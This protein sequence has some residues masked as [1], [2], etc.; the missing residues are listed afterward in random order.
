MSEQEKNHINVYLD[1]GE[2]PII[3]Y[4]PP[5]RFE[6]DTT[7][8]DDGPHTL[9]IEASDAT[10]NKGVR[11]IHFDVKNGPGIDVEGLKDQDILDGNVSILLNAYGGAKESLWEPS[12][13]ETPAP[14]PTWAWLLLLVI[15]AW[16]TYYITRQW[17]PPQKFA[18]TPTYSHYNG[19]K[20]STSAPPE[21]KNKQSAITT[22]SKNKVNGASIYASKCASCHQSNGKGIPGSFPPLAGDPVV[23]AKNPAQ[24]IRIVLNGLHGKSIQGTKYSAPM[25]AWG[26]Q[27]TD[28]QVA[29]II[30]HER[31]SW[32]NDAPTVSPKD[33]KK[34]R[35]KEK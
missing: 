35:N 19:M 2:E 10:G 17:N 14:V 4:Q 32:G 3:S 18:A 25:P 11:I 28:Q 23:T 22:A 12:R 27:L 6:L 31:T 20:A 34:I 15:V 1:G 33:V 13:A 5:V 30:N 16:S 9:K 21:K 7:Q 8:L 29:A 26:Q 24:H